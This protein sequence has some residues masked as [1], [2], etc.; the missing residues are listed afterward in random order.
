[1]QKS[2]ATREWTRETGVS[3]REAEHQRDAKLFLD[4]YPRWNIK[5][6]HCPIILHSL[7]RFYILLGRNGRRQRG[8][9]AEA[10]SKAYPGQIPRE[11]YLP[12]DWWAIGPPGK[13]SRTYTMR[14][15]Y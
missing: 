7:F 14:Y 5:R 2:Q 12:Y 6:P 4:E 13:K 1:M 9:S 10:A 11:T 15:T 3:I 8:S